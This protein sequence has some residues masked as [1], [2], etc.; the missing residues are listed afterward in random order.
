MTGPILVPAITATP[1]GLS[2]LATKLGEAIDII[3]SWNIRV[4]ESSRLPSAKRLLE[5]VSKLESYPTDANQLNRI[6]NSIRIA[7]DFYHITRVLPMDRVA[8]IA[9]DLR[10]ALGGT[11]DDVGPT[12]A[13]RAQSQ[14]LTAAVMAVGGLKPGAPRTDGNITPDYVIRVG[15][16]S[17]AVEIKRPESLAGLRSKIDEAIDQV[18]SLDTTGA[19]LVIDVSDCMS[20]DS[21]SSHG[22]ED[23]KRSFRRIWE[24]VREAVDTSS[25]PGAAKV[26][27]LFVF[28]NLFG[29]KPSNPPRPQP[30]FLTYQEV[31]H[32][33]RSGLI[34][35]AS[36]GVRRQVVAGF[37][38]FGADF[39]QVGAA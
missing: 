1:A 28:A 10:R 39:T 13:H 17:F 36:R 27:N 34:V 38:V 24:T 37:Q 12:A 31:F 5:Q 16:L 29:W 33:A 21:S 22:E 7:F 3:R 9:E 32:K 23:A 8:A 19:A 25:R 11:I 15:T 2:S 20:L 6:G 30:L 14:I 18:Q 26:S 35:E 4:S